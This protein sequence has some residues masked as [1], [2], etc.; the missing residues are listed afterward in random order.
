MD[1]RTRRSSCARA[2][3]YREVDSAVGKVCRRELTDLK[4]SPDSSE[5]GGKRFDHARARAI[6][7][8]FAQGQEKL[9]ARAGNFD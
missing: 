5:T 3:N 1:R 6:G 2:E 8:V 9:V 7:R 4:I